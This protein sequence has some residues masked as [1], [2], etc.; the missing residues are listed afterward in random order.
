M[1]ADRREL[2]RRIPQDPVF[3]ERTVRRPVD[4]EA[5]RMKIANW[6]ADLLFDDFLERE[7]LTHLKTGGGA[8]A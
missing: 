6:L 5:R 7:G 1:S 4:V 3:V 8:T 2:R